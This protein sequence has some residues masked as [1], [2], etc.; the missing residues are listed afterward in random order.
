MIIHFK[1][2]KERERYTFQN[3]TFHI[4]SLWTWLTDWAF[5]KKWTWSL[6]V[7]EQWTERERERESNCETM[8]FCDWW[9]RW[10]C[11]SDRSGETVSPWDWVR[12]WVREIESPWVREIES[13][14][15]KSGPWDSERWSLPVRGDYEPRERRRAWGGRSGV[16]REKKE[17]GWMF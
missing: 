4:V 8:S 17:R 12:E 9:R 14:S 16:R 10:H 11:E 2:K 13:K 5:F 1:V 6:E 3:Q 15:E 7:R